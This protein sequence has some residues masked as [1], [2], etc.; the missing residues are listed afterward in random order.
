LEEIRTLTVLVRNI[1]EKKHLLEA[2]AL[3]EMS[4]FHE[5]IVIVLRTEMS[6][7]VSHWQPLR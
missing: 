2:P 5:P 7:P 6:E 3:C 4:A 1:T